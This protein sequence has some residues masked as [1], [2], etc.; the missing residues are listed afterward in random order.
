MTDIEVRAA[1]EADLPKAASLRWQWSLENGQELAGTEAEYAERFTAWARGATQ[2]EC[3]VATRAGETIG[4]AWLAVTDRV[5]AADSFVRLSGDLQSVYVVPGERNHGV[6]ARLVHA[7]V[8]RARELGLQH[9]TV[10]SSSRAIPAYRRAG[11]QMLPRLMILDP[12]G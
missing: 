1:T 6:G 11:F 8:A 4:M 12:R 7:V 5:P 10:H 2:H 3:F 9:V